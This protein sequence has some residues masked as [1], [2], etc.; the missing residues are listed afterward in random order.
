MKELLL[1]FD[2]QYWKIALFYFIPAVVNLG[3][4]IYS[5]VFLPRSHTQVTFAQF[6]FCVLIWQVSDTVTRLSASVDTVKLWFQILSFGIIFITPA[7][8]HFALMFTNH[9]RWKKSVNLLGIL[10][11]PA[12]FFTVLSAAGIIPTD[13]VPSALWRWTYNLP[14]D[15]LGMVMVAWMSFLMYLMFFILL[16]NAWKKRKSVREE[17]R[18]AFLIVSGLALPIL[19]ATATQLVFP[20]AMNTEPAPIASALMVFFSVSAII[21]LSKFNLLLFSP[22]YAWADIVAT[23]NQGIVITDIKG[24]IHYANKYFYE[25]T[26]I[27]ETDLIGKKVTGL[28]FEDEIRKNCSILPS[29][30]NTAGAY[31]G[32]RCD[33]QIRIPDGERMIFSVG[34]SPYFNKT[35][36][37]I[38]RVF[39]FSDITHRKILE[40][41]L[42]G[43]IYDLN[44][45]VY[46]ASH[47]LRSPV[48]SVMGLCNLAM[49]EIKD[50]PAS[51][52]F[53][54]INRTI[55]RMDEIIRDLA[56]L[57]KITQAKLKFERVDIAGEINKILENLWHLERF[58]AT[59]IEIIS[60][61]VEFATDKT[62]LILILQ[63]LIVNAIN[64]GDPEKPGSFV[65]VR[66]DRAARGVKIGV[67]DNGV[68]IPAEIQP[69]IFD[70]FFRANESSKG[71]G[72]GLFIVKNAVEKLNGKISLK[73]K[74]G[75]GTV[76]AIFIPAEGIPDILSTAMS[77]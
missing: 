43:K 1:N 68:G 11:L 53:E 33:L 38:G 52:Y 5:F 59:R 47:D 35:G 54:K 58:S 27:L 46:R 3:L 64:Y 30:L 70:M 24:T 13:C 9:N 61:P 71:S 51:G 56:H 48:S 20:L 55:T 6:V 25:I 49:A 65:T 45:F 73:S 62:L 28:F 18:Q 10:Y 7:G 17:K 60:E 22:K 21:G 4:F 74:E 34:C 39:I 40:E 8:V 72:L 2:F 36:N 66:I 42:R 12:I 31:C 14:K 29:Q 76:F 15:I 50:E 63:N 44:M 19:Q 41:K 67:E 26:G 77:F 69:K 37:I 57:A 23:M 32:K 75:E 16:S